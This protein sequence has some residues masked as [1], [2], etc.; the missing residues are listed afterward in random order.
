[1]DSI[2][3][4]PQINA[5]AQRG[6]T[7]YYTALKRIRLNPGKLT[8]C[9][10]E[11][12]KARQLE[13]L[14]S[15]LRK[16]QNI[17]AEKYDDLSQSIIGLKKIL[18]ISNVSTKQFCQFLLEMEGNLIHLDKK[19]RTELEHFIDSDENELN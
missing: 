3:D 11:L 15:T 19:F 7:C 4:R 9:P 16:K 8:A 2:N 17:I 14:F 5:K 6:P 12:K 1:L 18:P 13:M 10:E